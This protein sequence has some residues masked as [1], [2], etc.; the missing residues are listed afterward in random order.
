MPRRQTFPSVHAVDNTVPVPPKLW[1]QVS[2][3]LTFLQHPFGTVPIYLVSPDTIDRLSSP[4]HWEL[5]PGCLRRVFADLRD[6]VRQ[7][8]QKKEDVDIGRFIDGLLK[9]CQRRRPVLLGC[10][11]ADAS[12]VGF[13]GSG[14]VHTV[15]QAAEAALK[16]RL[17]FPRGPAIFLCPDRIF[18]Y[19][20]GH[21]V[22]QIVLIHE[23]VHAYQG[24]TF[25]A[26]GASS[27]TWGRVIEESLANAVTFW[28]FQAQERPAVAAFMTSQP[29]EYA[30][31]VYWLG[32][33]G[34]GRD[35]R[36]ETRLLKEVL[37]AWREG[38]NG[39]WPLLWTEW[40]WWWRRHPFWFE[41]FEAVGPLAIYGGTP[42][43]WVAM[44]ELGRILNPGEMRDLIDRRQDRVIEDG[45][46]LLAVRILAE[47][48]PG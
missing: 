3:R 31:Y 7:A 35:R 47:V 36:A 48:I 26:R 41:W 33:T 10:Y 43:E 6:R 25:W 11:V 44:R 30:A 14:A 27:K 38:P 24:T 17:S 16:V 20:N 28:H 39:T 1:K 5:D 4:D 22:F 46:A 40:Y 9:E 29:A 12:T 32:L 2:Q 18:S 45:L 19:P 23:L 13:G 21:L 34:D 8:V 42:L 37:M 15:E